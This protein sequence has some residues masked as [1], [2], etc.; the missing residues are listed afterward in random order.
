MP[1][2]DSRGCS[3][4]SESWG[5]GLPSM[6]WSVTLG[7]FLHS[8]TRGDGDPHRWSWEE[9]GGADASSRHEGAGNLQAMTEIMRSQLGP[10][11]NFDLQQLRRSLDVRQ[12]MPK[13]LYKAENWGHPANRSLRNTSFY[14]FLLC[15][16]STSL[17]FSAF[18]AAFQRRLTSCRWNWL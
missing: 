11:L 6:P 17:L 8:F 9:R 13:I 2:V 16:F 1:L 4:F 12:Q 5:G 10:Y 3:S 18:A 7:S 14:A 15:L